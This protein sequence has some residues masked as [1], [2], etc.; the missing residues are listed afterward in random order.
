MGVTKKTNKKQNNIKSM[1]GF[2]R[3]S[4][5][6]PY[7]R[8]TAEIKTLN[9]RSLSVTCNP[10]NGLFLLE[11]RTKEL[12]ESKVFRGKIFVRISLE[13]AGQKKNI[14][15]VRV[16]ES[17]AEEYLTKIRKLQKKLGLN[18]DVQIQELISLPG[19]VGDKTEQKEENIWPH[20]R[21]ALQKAIKKLVKYREEEG[22]RLARDFRGRISG[23]QKSIKE[24][25]KYEEKGIEDYRKK[26]IRSIREIAENVDADKS[27]LETEVASF[28]KNC[29]IAEEVTRLEGHIIA[30]IKTMKD[31]KTDIGKKLD[32]IA[33]EMQRE[34]NTIGAKASDF[35]VSKAVIDI[36]SEIEKMREQIKNIE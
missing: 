9:H 26:L 17:L 2:G 23:I 15:K 8:I 36:K 29:D 19:V 4:V 13:E 11:E 14:E 33:Q 27:R 7:G 28:A 12:L 16:N 25:K 34:A 6:S 31:V 3:E 30:Y 21:T 24:V 1:T 20:V 10:F 32:F 22:A 18:G 35:R 5:K